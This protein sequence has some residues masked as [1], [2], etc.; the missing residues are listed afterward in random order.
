MPTANEI[1]AELVPKALA[2]DQQALA[3][4]WANIAPWIDIRIRHA[5]VPRCD[6]EDLHREIEALIWQMLPR[7]DPRRSAFSSW[8]RFP[9][10]TSI[11]RYYRAYRRWTVDD[12]LRSSGSSQE[13][14]DGGELVTLLSGSACARPQPRPDQACEDHDTLRVLLATLDPESASIVA[15]VHLH[16]MTMTEAARKRGVNY[17]VVQRRL[18]MA[19][20]DLRAAAVELGI[21]A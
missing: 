18:S 4:L 13:D 2:G 14:R 6:R 5:K 1:S 11:R 8:L 3:D 9:I 7:W 19:M 17:W 12:R 15:D 16:G 21:A 10:G 20:D